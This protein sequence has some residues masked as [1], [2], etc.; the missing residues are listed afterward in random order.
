MNDEFDRMLS[1]PYYFRPLWEAERNLV[2]LAGRSQCDRIHPGALYGITSDHDTIRDIVARGF[3]ERAEKSKLGQFEVGISVNDWDVGYKPTKLARDFAAL[4][5]TVY[6]DLRRG[7]LLW[8]RSVVGAKARSGPFMQNLN[9][10]KFRELVVVF[11]RD[12]AAM[13]KALLD[14]NHLG[15]ASVQLTRWQNGELDDYASN[16]SITEKGLTYLDSGGNVT[17]NTLNISHS[18]VGVGD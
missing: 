11:D 1:D 7:I 5:F 18:T 4:N 14:L 6:T 17:L 13:E 9:H 12:E 2:L 3:L 8:L 16:I 10:V 15:L